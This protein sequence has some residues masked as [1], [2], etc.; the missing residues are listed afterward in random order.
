MTT[1]FG[2]N[3]QNDLYLDASGNLAILSGLPAVE[4]CCATASKGQLGEMILETV[5]G[6]PNFEAVWIGTPN[7]SV[8]QS[9]LVNA[10]NNVFGVNEVTSIT[11]SA[12]NGNLSYIATIASQYGP[13]EIIGAVQP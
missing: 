11:F 7:Y 4:Q 12:E 1:T 8:W 13:A 5:L 10:L 6:L 9:Y 2:L 3:D